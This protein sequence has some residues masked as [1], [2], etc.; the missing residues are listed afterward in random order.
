MMA[1]T[2]KQIEDAKKRYE[3]HFHTHFPEHVLF[4]VGNPIHLENVDEIS[5]DDLK[6][7]DKA[8]R[9]NKPFDDD[10]LEK[11]IF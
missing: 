9:E 4:Q 6:S 10:V 7:V 11:V 8:I 3:A 1:I 5:K 2:Q